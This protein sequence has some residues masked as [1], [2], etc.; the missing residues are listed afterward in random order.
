[1]FGLDWFQLHCYDL[2]GVSVDCVVDLAEGATGDSLEELVVLA[3]Y[4]LHA[5]LL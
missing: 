2:L 1:M 3:Y 4:D 5:I